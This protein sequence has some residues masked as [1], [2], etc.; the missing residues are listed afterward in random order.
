MPRNTI[1]NKII[2]QVFGSDATNKEKL[3]L[4]N[5]APTGVGRE[6]C[7]RFLFEDQE[8]CT[9]QPCLAKYGLKQGQFLGAGSSSVV[10]AACEGDSPCPAAV[11]ASREPLDEEVE[12]YKKASDVGAAP[13]FIGHEKH[14]AMQDGSTL[15]L[16]ITE[17]FDCSLAQFLKDS[18][19]EP[20]RNSE[21]IRYYILERIL[22]TVNTLRTV[23][24]TH[25]DLN[26]DNV[27]LRCNLWREAVCGKGDKS[28]VVTTIE[29]DLEGNIDVKFV[30][31]G[32]VTMTPM[33]DESF[34]WHRHSV[35]LRFQRL[36]FE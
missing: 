27:V 8:Y 34:F 22:D 4:N 2:A 1:H 5:L 19:Y 7:Y 20:L 29:N 36:L 11:K 30:D 18:V 35:K 3:C 21:H 33:N 23:N 15:E 25:Y 10:Y 16:M 13:R 17:R 24:I 28:T 32:D 26:A 6:E 14:C 31:F 12:A 9:K